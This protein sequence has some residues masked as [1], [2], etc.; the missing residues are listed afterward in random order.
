MYVCVC[1]RIHVSVRVGIIEAICGCMCM[2][3]QCRHAYAHASRYVCENVYTKAKGGCQVPFS[4]ILC[5]IP[6]RQSLPLNLEPYWHPEGS[7]PWWFC[8]SLTLPQPWASKYTQPYPAL[9]MWMAAELRSHACVQ[10]ALLPTELIPS[11]RVSKFPRFL[12][13]EASNEKW[14]K[15]R[16]Q[17]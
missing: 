10:Q 12:V 4:I 3:K 5:N 8:L 14:E 15:K 11:F 7:K 6:L 13:T 2:W 1:V 9:F 16:E 17:G